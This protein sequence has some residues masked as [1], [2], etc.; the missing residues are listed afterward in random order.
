MTGWRRTGA[1]HVT[2]LLIFG[3]ILL[4]LFIVSTARHGASFNQATIISR[5]NCST[6]AY[7]TQSLHLIISLISTGIFASSNFF[8]QIAT[9]PS[10]LDIDKAHSQ[11]RSLDIGILS[12]R[13]LEA[14]SQGKRIAC[15]VLLLSSIPIHLLFNSSIFGTVF[16]GS[17]W[18]LMIVTESFTLGADFYPPGASLS[19]S[20]SSWPSLG[21]DPGFGEVIPLTE[22]WNSTS[23]VYQKVTKTAKSA[24][25]WDRLDAKH[26]RIEYAGCRPRQGYGDVVIV[27]KP[28][29]GNQSGWTRK[30]IFDFKPGNLTSFWD[31]HIPPN[32]INPL[33]FSAECSITKSGGYVHTLGC[34]HN[35]AQALG[36]GY[37]EIPENHSIPPS[38][39]WLFTFQRSESNLPVEYGYSSKFDS[40]TVSYCLAEPLPDNCKVVLSNYLLLTIIICIF[41]KVA[42]CTV[43][44]W[45]LRRRSLVTPGDVIESFI[46][47]PDQQTAGLGTLDIFDCRR[48]ENEPPD[49]WPEE[50]DPALT[51]T[52]TPRAWHT[53]N[54]R[55]THILPAVVW[56][57]TYGYLSL[58]VALVTFIM[59]EAFVSNSYTFPD[60]FG[61]ADDSGIFPHG[62][63]GYL[64]S[65]LFVNVPHLFVST[66]YF[67][68]NAFFTQVQVEHEWN[69][70]SSKFKPLRVSHPMG[71][72]ISSYRLQLPY[73]YSIPLIL[74]GI[75]CHWLVSNTVFL[76]IIEGDRSLIATGYSAS[77]TLL[78]FI[79]TLVLVPLPLLFSLYKLKGEMIAGGSNSLVISAACHCHIS[80]SQ[81]R[82]ESS[83][84]GQ[85]GT[86]GEI[87][88]VEEDTRSITNEE[89]DDLKEG[90][91]QLARSQLRWGRMSI[92]QY[93]EERMND[94]D[95]HRTLHLGFGDKTMIDGGPEEGQ[96]YV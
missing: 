46:V 4:I 21:A 54:K 82:Q 56:A 40:F 95:R 18:H 44:L 25:H 58:M 65:L 42:T 85:E 73:K 91:Q 89:A 87:P 8:M 62:N 67:F 83:P 33:W 28:K 34:R 55:L 70:Y 39:E 13:N 17:D 1:I 68:Y 27:V 78:L 64:N 45:K 29:I 79:T 74:G 3:T 23:P 32:E 31:P 14:L 19:P 53:K 24:Q 6:A 75:W 90:L 84:L 38:P 9:S 93:V 52:V 26:C 71:Q 49:I 61:N 11:L 35:C 2:C 69:E 81:R 7:L 50:G 43:I 86:A 10:R 92:P 94:N 60:R 76:C 5:T 37:V 96:R 63:W 16:Q 41:L 80:P 22:Y 88:V 36:V 48:F 72:Q 59:I 77:A 66:S 30:Q 12:F 15:A 51:T 47:K 20:G 57:R